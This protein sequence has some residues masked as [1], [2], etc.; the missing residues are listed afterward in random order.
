MRSLAACLA[1]AGLLLLPQSAGA[2]ATSAFFPVEFAERELVF[3]E[4]ATAALTLSSAA[5][6]QWLRFDVTE[7]VR[8]WQDGAA[9]NHGVLVKLAQEQEE[10]DS[11]GPYLPA[12]S[13][14]DPGMW[15]RLVVT[16]SSP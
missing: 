13:F 16:H 10:Y 11:S 3:D 9:P 1:L 4:V 7:L 8:A 14:S 5:V 2:T 6:P 12:S 15:P